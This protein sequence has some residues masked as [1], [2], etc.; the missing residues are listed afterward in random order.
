MGNIPAY[1]GMTEGQYTPDKV[2]QFVP[3]G[4]KF[5]HLNKPTAGTQS[6][7][8]LPRGKHPLQLYSLG[9]PNGVKVT[10]LLEQ[11]NQRYGLEYDAWY[12][13]ILEGDQFGSEFV[14]GNP[15][16]KIPMLLHYTS[17]DATPV[18]VFETS[19]ILI[20]LCEQFDTDNAYLPP[21]KEAAHRAECMSWLLW[22]HGSAPYLGG[23]FGHFF[24]YAPVKIKYAIDRYTMEAKRQLDVLDRHLGEHQF[25]CGDSVTIA[26]FACWPWYGECVY[27]DKAREFLQYDSY[28]NVAAWS[29]RMKE[30]PSV[31][32]GRV[33]NKTW[34]ESAMKERHSASDFEE[35]LPNSAE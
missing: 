21:I 3:Q 15:N 34:G 22:V 32:R 18:R 5:G 4:G 2:W 29:E 10:C 35:V 27:G 17:E 20:Y 24:N 11:L 33:V 16:S 19:A 31:K 9:T 1:F 6:E 12:I 23:G 25:L 30:L 8:A 13:N 26:D 28:T 14:E 7:K